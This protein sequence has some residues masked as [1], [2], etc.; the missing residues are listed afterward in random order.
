[1]TAQT[2]VVFRIV[3]YPGILSMR[4]CVQSCLDAVLAACQKVGK[5]FYVAESH[6]PRHGLLNGNFYLFA[7][8]RRGFFSVFVKDGHNQAIEKSTIGFSVF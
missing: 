3:E 4:P 7:L 2:E 6:R 1:M 8:R 5:G